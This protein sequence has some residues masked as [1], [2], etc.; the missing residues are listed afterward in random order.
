MDGSESLF[1]FNKIRDIAVLGW[2]SALKKVDGAIQNNCRSSARATL[3]PIA[4]VDAGELRRTR[5]IAAGSTQSLKG[6]PMRKAPGLRA[7]TGT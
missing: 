3:L 6:A 2:R 7:S 5:S 4:V 1:H